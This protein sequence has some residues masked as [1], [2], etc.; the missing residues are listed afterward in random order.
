MGAGVRDAMNLAW[1][2]AGVVV[3]DLPAA[4]LDSYEQER[5]PHTRHMIRLALSVG[6]AMTAGGRFGNLMRR[7][8]VTRAQLIPGLRSKILDS[9]TP[10]LHRSALSHRS[11]GPRQLAAALCPNPVLADGRRLD[12]VLGNGFALIT[13]RAL[14]IAQ[15]TAVEEVGA[16]VLVAEAGGELA[17]WLSRGRVQAAVIRPD[18]T[19][20]C[21]S[22][23]LHDPY[24]AMPTFRPDQR[25]RSDA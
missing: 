3:G 14:S 13:S 8:V 24:A 2:L 17:D 6:W 7:L 15:R 12:S 9:R 11:R 20:M 4:V 19:V 18:R 1:K 10:A 16:T 5:K 22:R 21:T 25:M 23:D